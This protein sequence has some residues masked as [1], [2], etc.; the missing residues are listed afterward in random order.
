MARAEQTVLRRVAA[1][2][3][4]TAAVWSALARDEAEVR[5]TGTARPAEPPASGFAGLERMAVR[6]YEEINRDR[7]LLIG[8]GVTFYGLL[9]LFPAITVL[10]SIYGLFA[11][12]TAIEG[13]VQSLAGVL[14]GGAI[15]VLSDQL[16]RIASQSGGSLGLALI[17]GLVVAL[18]SANSGMKAIFEG[19][20]AVYDT[21]EGRSFIRLTLV[22]L[23]FTI[24]A[25]IGLLLA[26]GAIVAVPAILSFIGLDGIGDV[27]VRYGSWVLLLA[28]VVL[29]LSLLYRYGADR[30]PPSWQWV[31]TGAAVAAVVWLIA[32]ALFSW[33]VANFGNYNATYGSLG[34]VIG[35]MVWLW[36]SASIVLAG[37]ELDAELE[38]RLSGRRPD[39]AGR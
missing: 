23:L 35:F 22:S 17:G 31:S 36:I 18:W 12:P 37:A 28:L 24:G 30:P 14:P 6:L 21:R 25:M 39:R 34:A 13:Q 1:A 7:V 19:L 20:N 2:V 26:L 8:A 10:V 11:D 16:H 9:S 32:S 15:S 4:A 3:V 38:R 5:R 33:L 29:G 27:L